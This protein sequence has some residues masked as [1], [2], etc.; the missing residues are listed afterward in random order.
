MRV[1]CGTPLIMSVTM[2]S[3]SF[4]LT[5][6]TAPAPASR[7]FLQAST[8]GIIPPDIVPS[9]MSSS[10]LSR[11]SSSIFDEGSDTSISIP[12]T[13]VMAIISVHPAPAAMPAA[14]VSALTFSILPSA[15][16]PIG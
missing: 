16:L 4:P 2:L 9:A 15:S 1:P 7:A 13:S 3:G 14:I 8:L 12:G 11:V 5:M 10:T 6:R